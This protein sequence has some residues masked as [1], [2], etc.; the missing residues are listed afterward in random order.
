MPNRKRKGTFS[1]ETPPKKKY[2]KKITFFSWSGPRRAR[3][4]QNYIET[5]FFF[6]AR[7]A[8]PMRDKIKFSHSLSK[9]N[10]Y[11]LMT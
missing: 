6:G 3:A 2:P 8:Y 5:A 1:M 10:V 11:G 7:G 4:H 9:V